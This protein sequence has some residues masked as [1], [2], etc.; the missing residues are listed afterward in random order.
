MARDVFSP[1]FVYSIFEIELFVV[2][3]KANDDGRNEFGFFPLWSHHGRPF[4]TKGGQRKTT[5]PFVVI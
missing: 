1:L 4:F 2:A 5:L 3:A